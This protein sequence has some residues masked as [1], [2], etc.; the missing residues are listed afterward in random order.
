MAIKY[1][2]VDGELYG[3]EDINDIARNLV[4]AGVMPFLAKESY[5][6]SDLNLITKDIVES[7]TSLEGCKCTMQN[8]GAEDMYISIGQ[9]IVFFESGVRLTVD[10]AGYVV[11]AVP[12]IHGYI[13][14]HYSP[15][16]QKADIVFAAE[17]PTDGEIV[18]LAEVLAD[19]SLRDKRVFARSKV[20]TMGRNISLTANFE[21]VTPTLIRE[22]E[23]FSHYKIA[24]VPG[25][26]LSKFNYAI[27]TNGELSFEK[28]QLTCFYDLVKNKGI[29]S[30]QNYN[31]VASGNLF[32]TVI[33]YSVWNTLEVCDS[34][35]CIVAVCS[36]VNSNQGDLNY[37]A[38]RD[39]S[40]YTA[41]FM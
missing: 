32:Q 10:E 15:S 22:D 41:T 12:N 6:V 7:G 35:L 30:I 31:A 33:N 18:I 34:E 26:D 24:R 36:I 25:V 38:N 27:M 11:A 4:G 37:V 39:Y 28:V 13:F 17:L 19:G 5:N 8:A 16:L 23:S 20:A 1:S 21:N 29:F 3:T 9:G 2:F 14:A 40:Y